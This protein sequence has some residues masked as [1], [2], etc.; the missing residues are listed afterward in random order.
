MLFE[1]VV[2]GAS[3]ALAAT[4][5]G[6]SAV[7][8][9]KKIDCKAQALAISF[10]AGMMAFSAFE[11][12]LQSN[13]GAGFATTIAGAAFGLATFFAVEKL[14][15]H[16]HLAIRKRRMENS[17]KKMALMAGTVTLHNIPEGFAIAA[18]FASSSPLGWLVSTSIALQDIPE[19]TVVSVPVACYGASTGRSFM[20]GAF[21]GLVE[22][23]A[24][25]VGYFFLN[26]IQPLVP[27]ALAFSGGA[28]AYVALFELL[29]DAFGNG[30]WKEPAISVAAGVLAAFSLAAAFGI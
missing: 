20:I 12:M 18:A 14:L 24:A 26:Q 5:L 9:F 13:S 27:F 25:I 7:L 4:C 30:S 22:F 2:F 15:P 3:V 23:S 29:P 28:M 11:M 21:S 17:K 6:A 10:C 19:G 8:A 1:E 16:A